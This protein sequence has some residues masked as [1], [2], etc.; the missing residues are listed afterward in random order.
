MT[1]T[2]KPATTTDSS[3]SMA[4]PL[5]FSLVST[6]GAAE[7]GRDEGEGRGSFSGKQV[8]GVVFFVFVL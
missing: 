2:A 4:E 3:M 5:W 1:N 6:R 8:A 7:T